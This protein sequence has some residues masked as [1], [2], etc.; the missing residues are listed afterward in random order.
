M[1]CPRMVACLL[2]VVTG[3]ATPRLTRHPLRR[4]VPSVGRLARAT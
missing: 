4:Y 3:K 1:N 2:T